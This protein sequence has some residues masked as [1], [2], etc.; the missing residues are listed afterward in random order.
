MQ[1]KRIFVCT[2]PRHIHRQKIPNYKNQ[3]LLSLLYQNQK[4]I[5]KCFYASNYSTQNGYIYDALSE[6]N[7]LSQLKNTH[8]CSKVYGISY[9]PKTGIYF[10]M[11]HYNT[12]QNIYDFILSPYYWKGEYIM[13]RDLKCKITRSMCDA[14]QELYSLSI[15]HC[16]IKLI[17]SLFI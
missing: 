3:S 2:L 5:S 12:I 9:V 8:Y 1:R 4:Y 16:D 14:F 17:N 11:K 6:L 7:I 15:I 13:D 10:I